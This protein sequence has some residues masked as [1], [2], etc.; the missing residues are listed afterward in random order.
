LWLLRHGNK[1]KKEAGKSSFE[2]IDDYSVE[3]CLRATLLHDFEEAGQ[4]EAVW[5]DVKTIKQQGKPGVI[6]LINK[7]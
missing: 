3:M 2:L 5:K 6:F 4:S 1:S 7:F